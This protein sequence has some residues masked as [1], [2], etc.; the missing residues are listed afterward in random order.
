[1]LKI[2]DTKEEY[3]KYSQNNTNLD[4]GVLYYVK[5]NR[6]AHFLTN[7]IDGENK[8]YNL[9]DDIDPE[10]LIIV[11]SQTNAPLMAVLYAKGLAAN[12]NY[13]T[14]AE[15]QAVTNEQLNGLLNAN[16]TV[17][18]FNEFK[19]FTGVTKICTSDDAETSKTLS[20][21]KGCTSLR[22]ITLPKTVNE[23]G[24]RAFDLTKNVNVIN[25]LENIHK[26]GHCSLQA[27]FGKSSTQDFDYIRV[28]ELKGGNNFNNVYKA[29]NGYGIKKLE[30]SEGVEDIRVSAFFRMNKLEE[31]IL[32]NSLKTIGGLASNAGACF[33]GCNNLKR[34]NSNV[35]GVINIPDSVTM[36]GWQAFY[37]PTHGN[38]NIKE[39]NIPDS[40]EYIGQNAFGGYYKCERINIGKGIK[41]MD[42]SCI[43]NAGRDTEQL[44]ITIKAKNPPAWTP[45]DNI[46]VDKVKIYVPSESIYAYKSAAG[47]SEYADI[48]YAK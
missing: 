32:P 23:L 22:E 46:Q 15:A 27:T 16:T 20:P 8:V 5:E 28:D 24:A 39:I 21:F 34:L 30:I 33:A 11:S 36:I 41:T 13:M 18:N 2:F 48:I 26:F 25:G 43:I 14:L 17:V 37:C 31:I 7:N 10:G 3:N 40:V 29:T 44:T 6:N 4:S 42:T 12:E 35:D 1:M 47:W 9:V 19:Y 45:H 38:N